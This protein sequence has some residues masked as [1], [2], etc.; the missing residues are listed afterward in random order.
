MVAGL[1]G[2][3]TAPAVAGATATHTAA[4][5]TRTATA[6]GA[7]ADETVDLL[8]ADGLRLCGRWRFPSGHGDAPATV[9]VV[10]GF[11]ASQ[12]DLAVCA[13][14]DDLAAAGYEVLTYDA[15]GHGASEGMSA[16]GSTEHIDVACAVDVASVRGL[17]VVLVGVSMGGVAVAGYLADRTRG[18][19]R[20]VDAAGAGVGVGAGDGGHAGG[21]EGGHGVAGAVLVSTPSRWRM[22]PSPLGLVTAVLTRT[23]LGRWV[24]SRR[25]RV[26]IAPSWRVGEPLE[27]LVERIDVPLAVVHGTGDRLLRPEHGRR[28]HASAAGPSRLELVEGMRHGIDVSK[29]HATVGAVGWVLSWARAAASAA[30]ER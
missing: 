28:L 2:A 3:G 20:S 4:T 30:P 10:H 9:V 16:V 11:S 13:L 1:E 5:V 23:R 14:A 22:R 27:A 17:P 19:D 7:S 29:L 25:L 18:D 15:R 26:R 6:H 12:D 21:H 24:A 8:T